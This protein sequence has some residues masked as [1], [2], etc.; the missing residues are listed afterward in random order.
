[1]YGGKALTHERNSGVL[2]LIKIESAN[3]AS[4]LIHRVEFD[5]DITLHVP[6]SREFGRLWSVRLALLVGITRSTGCS[7]TL[8]TI[9]DHRM[10][11]TVYI[12]LFN[13]ERCD[14]LTAKNERKCLVVFG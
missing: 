3:E 2:R 12:K 7:D 14:G 4:A 6:A 11:R 9:Q 1:M 13:R 10:G 8:S 5:V